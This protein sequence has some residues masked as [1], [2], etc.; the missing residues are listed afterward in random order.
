MQRV[1]R[2]SN[3]A[4]LLDPGGDEV[5]PPRFEMIE[6]TD[7]A[8]ETFRRTVRDRLAA[9]T[10]RT[11]GAAHEINNPCA[12]VTANLS[13]LKL[14][15]E[16]MQAQL[17]VLATG[18][19]KTALTEVHKDLCEVVT[20]SAEALRRIADLTRSLAQPS[21]RHTRRSEAIIPVDVGPI[22]RR[23][24]RL[25]GQCVDVQVMYRGDSTQITAPA[26]VICDLV[27]NLLIAALEDGTEA[28]RPHSTTTVEVE[29]FSDGDEH[30]I[31][32]TRQGSTS[33]APR[34]DVELTEAA[35]LIE[36]VDGEVNVQTISRTSYSIVARI[37][38]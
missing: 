4:E 15:A 2:R 21:L 26:S 1:V 32:V 37:P 10:L 23:A 14:R 3:V 36:L 25:L 16:D 34:V 5:A 22:A 38:D 18:D 17:D 8:R 9:L 27:L 6:G 30:V 28:R 13:Y 11:G 20:E 35:R 24:V 33:F 31:K 19:I 7:P 29:A 12:S